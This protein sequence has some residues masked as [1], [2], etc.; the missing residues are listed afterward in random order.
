M[1]SSP[2]AQIAVPTPDPIIV[3]VYFEGTANTLD[4]FTTQIGLF[5]A[6]TDALDLREA[7]L[8]CHVPEDQTKD[9]EGD[10]EG[11][12]EGDREGKCPPGLQIQYKLAFDG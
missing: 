5:S 1:H 2:P 6:L 3:T 4:S 10:R 11:V 9:G 12:R 8:P 7:R